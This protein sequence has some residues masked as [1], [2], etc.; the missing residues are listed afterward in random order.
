MRVVPRA[1]AA[2]LTVL[3]HLLILSALVRVTASVIRKPPPA[4]TAQEI[5]ADKLRGAGDQMIVSV[6]IRPGLSTNGLACAGSS[7]VG[8]GV[9]ADPGTERIIL[10]GDNTPASRAGLQHDDIVLNPVVWREAHREGALLQVL[11][12]REGAKIWVPVRV[13][14]ICIG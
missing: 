10:V 12:L 9:T 4:P 1:V 13:G 2:I 5:S 14:K 8:V 6:D 3:L 7:Y 11:I